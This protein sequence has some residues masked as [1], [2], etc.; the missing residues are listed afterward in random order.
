MNF[1]K[2]LSKSIG[3]IVCTLA[4][5]AQEIRELSITSQGAQLFGTWVKCRN[6][7]TLVILHPGSG[8]TDRDGNQE[9]LTTNLLLKFS[10]F[11][12]TQ[13]ISSFRLD[14]RGIGKS[15][16]GLESESQLT[17]DYYV[18]DLYRW[19]GWFR[20]S[21]GYSNIILLGH[22]E[23]ALIAL[24]C[25]HDY[26]KCAHLISISGAGRP[27]DIILKEQLK[28][29]PA[30]VQ[31]ALFP[32]IDTLLAGRD[33]KNV[34]PIFYAL[35]RPSVQPYLRSWFSLNPVTL[36]QAI[37]S[38]VLIVQG[39]ADIQVS[40]E[41][42]QLLQSAFSNNR[43]VW[44]KNTNHVLTKSKTLNKTQQMTDYTDVSQKLPRK[45]K[46]ELKRYVK[47]IF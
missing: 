28:T 36:A 19:I 16:L 8:P 11:F 43:T 13:G 46:Q 7:K 42:A 2:L 41:D 24:K 25:L 10:N 15:D 17:I 12:S 45:L 29:L 3:I 34:P 26:P 27:A 21:L 1:F 33:I 35:F 32:M 18:R 37:K 31:N 39:T 44:L 20:D 23:G 38:P 40:K 30:K 4:C 5:Q 47:L 14:K 22:S 9:G 6:P